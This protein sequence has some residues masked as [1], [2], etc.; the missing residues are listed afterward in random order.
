MFSNDL[1]QAYLNTTYQVGNCN[2]KIKIGQIDENLERMLDERSLEEWAF[3]TAY[4][5]HSVSLTENE[6]ASR[7]Q[8][9]QNDVSSFTYFEG[10]GVG[11]DPTW[12]PEKSLLILGL[13]RESAIELGLKYGQ[14]AIVIG[15]KELAAELLVIFKD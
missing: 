2:I 12:E 13:N 1:L 9:L 8:Q 11:E 3:I 7:H 5:P 15:R 10:D 4:N 14:N 6:N